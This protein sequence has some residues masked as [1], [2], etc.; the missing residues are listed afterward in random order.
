MRTGKQNQL[1][2]FDREAGVHSSEKVKLPPSCSRS[3]QPASV[4]R[5]QQT[6]PVRVC[7]C[8]GEISEAALKI[9]RF[10]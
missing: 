8:W 10:Q 4:K 5:S 7:V 6:G 2:F 1:P 3:L 9:F